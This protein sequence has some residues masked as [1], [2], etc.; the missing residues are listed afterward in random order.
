MSVPFASMPKRLARY[1][2]RWKMIFA[3]EPEASDIVFGL[4]QSG[5]LAMLQKL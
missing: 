3:G 2:G 1:E 5:D 4:Q